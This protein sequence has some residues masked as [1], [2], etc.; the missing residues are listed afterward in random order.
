VSGLD[1]HPQVLALLQ[2]AREQ[3]WDD[4][5]R[6][7]LADWFEEAGDPDRA[8]FLRLQCALAPGAGTLGEAEQESARQRVAEL[9]TRFGGAWLGPLW[10][11]GGIW[12]RGLLSVLLDRLRLPE[13]LADMQPWIDSVHCE[14]PGRD[15]LRWALSLLAGHNHITLTLHRPFP[16]DVLLALLGEALPEPCLRT[17]T[18][19][20]SPGMGRHTDQ[21]GY[22]NLP[23]T[24]FSRLA[25]LPLCRHLSHLGSTLQFT[26]EQAVV[27]RAASI[28]PML[29][30]HPHWPHLLAPTVFRR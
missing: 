6:L 15:A 1:R 19:R 4:M 24:F 8:E 16:A 28:E 9:I 27:V 29:V 11:H 10:Q 30:R 5:P 13:G 25:A 7:V 23:T 12:H 17:L 20:W 2:T 18:F 22:V 3:P 26:E 14:V 21:G